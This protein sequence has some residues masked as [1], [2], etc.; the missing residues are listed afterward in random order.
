MYRLALAVLTSDCCWLYLRV[1]QIWWWSRFCCLPTRITSRSIS[2]RPPTIMATTSQSYEELRCRPTLSFHSAPTCLP[3]KVSSTGS[4]P[5]LVRLSAHTSLKHSTASSPN[6]QQVQINN[7]L[8]ICRICIS[9]MCMIK[10]GPSKINRKFLEI[11]LAN[12]LCGWMPLPTKAHT[13]LCI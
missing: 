10:P 8:N 1:V 2:C 9:F 5:A 4:T 11:T 12:S 13:T 7:Y 6:C 3:M